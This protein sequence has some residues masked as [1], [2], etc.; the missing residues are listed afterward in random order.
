MIIRNHHGLLF[1]KDFFDAVHYALGSTERTTLPQVM[2][3]GFNFLWKEKKTPTSLAR[4]GWLWIIFLI[5]LVFRIWKKCMYIVSKVYSKA[6]C[7]RL[8]HCFSILPLKAC[9]FLSRG[10]YYK[11]SRKHS[12][13]IVKTNG[14]IQDKHMQC[15]NETEFDSLKQKLCQETLDTTSGFPMTFDIRWLQVQCLSNIFMLWFSFRIVVG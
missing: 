15:I 2:I 9:S 10:K 14:W 1:C 11:E 4:R 13:R 8:W 3:K 12:L 6:Y 5:T 7:M